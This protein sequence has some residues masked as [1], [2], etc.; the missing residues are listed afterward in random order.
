V[1]LVDAVGDRSDSTKNFKPNSAH[2]RPGDLVLVIDSARFEP[3]GLARIAAT[4]VASKEGE[5]LTRLALDGGIP[6]VV[7]RDA[8]GEPLSISK[9]T[10][11]CFSN[12][13]APVEDFLIN[14]AN[15]SDGL[16]IKRCLFADNTVC[17]V[18]MK[19][20]HGLIA[21]NRFERNPSAG[22]TLWTELNWQEG[23]LARHLLVRDNTF[24][25]HESGDGGY[26][27]ACAYRPGK[28]YPKYA[29]PIVGPVTL[30]NNTFI[31]C[32]LPTIR[33]Q[34]CHDITLSGNTFSPP[35]AAPQVE[36]GQFTEN[37][38]L[39]DISPEAISY[40]GP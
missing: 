31:D 40:D 38:D 37:L 18:K 24:V 23:Y 12:P 7:S 19:G 9:S 17:A 15:K 2:Y 30:K 13:D 36:I 4:S 27:L 14:L 16:V 26:V 22:L 20:S 10:H 11:F 25:G 8:I 39:R 34:R 33:L 32:A 6:G 3:R 5:S 28:K 1:L 21:E 29:A 35:E